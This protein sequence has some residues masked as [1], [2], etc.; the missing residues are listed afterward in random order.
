MQKV[1]RGMRHDDYESKVKQ[2]G[3][4]ST[5][6]DFWRYW[7]NFVDPAQFPRN[8]NLRL[9]K[10]S[11]KPMWEDDMNRAGGR[12]TWYDRD[13]AAHPR[14]TCLLVVLRGLCAWVQV[15]EAPTH[16]PPVDVADACNDW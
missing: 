6:Q 5:V 8:S 1:A 9:F 7:N 15:Y 13:R 10:S 16:K 2:V 3:T 14:R 12:W 4:F 11:I